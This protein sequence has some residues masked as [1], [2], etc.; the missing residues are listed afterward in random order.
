MMENRVHLSQAGRQAGRQGNS[1]LLV[2]S[3]TAYY[4]TKN[5]RRDTGELCC[6]GRFLR[7]S[8]RLF[9]ANCGAAAEKEEGYP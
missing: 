7:V 9:G 1:C 4:Q 3:K 2:L 5:V 8:Q 6:G